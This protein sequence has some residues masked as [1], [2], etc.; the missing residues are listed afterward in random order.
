MLG[1][2]YGHPTLVSDVPLQILLNPN[3]YYNQ[4]F[5]NTFDCNH[6]TNSDQLL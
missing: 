5:Y 1:I 2:R 6:F 4:I 3:N